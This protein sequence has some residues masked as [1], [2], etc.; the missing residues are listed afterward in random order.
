MIAFPKLPRAV[1]AKHREKMNVFFASWAVHDA[2]KTFMIPLC[3][4]SMAFEPASTAWGSFASPVVE[5]VKWAN[6][7]ESMNV[8]FAS[9]AVHDAKKTFMIPLCLLSMAFEPAST[10]WGS[11][12]SPV[13]EAVK[14]ANHRESMNVFFASWAVHDAF[15]TFM[16]PLCLLSVII[17]QR[18]V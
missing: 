4:L 10:A 1:Q 11:F 9:W 6:H 8:F 15:K 17:Q 16:I 14:W 3:L 12:A 18:N 5:A 2:K 7:R 13:V